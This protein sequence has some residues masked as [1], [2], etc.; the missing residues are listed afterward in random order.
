MRVFMG[1]GASKGEA[2]IMRSRLCL[3]VAVALIGCGPEG[4]G[5]LGPD[6]SYLT[7]ITVVTLQ[8]GQDLLVADSVLRLSFAAV[9]EDSRCPTDV[10]C[11]WEGNA[12]VELGISAGTGPT[13]PLRLNTSQ[14]PGSAVWNGVLVTLLEVTPAPT[15]EST[16]PTEAY[17]VTLRLEPRN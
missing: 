10:V 15:S 1:I 13:F 7:S 11:V 4:E 14:E 3:L 17:S 5:N 2:E 6:A 16:I 9:L 8:Y 12:G